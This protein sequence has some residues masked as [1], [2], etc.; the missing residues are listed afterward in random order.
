MLHYT[1]PHIGTGL[2]RSPYLHL[3]RDCERIEPRASVWSAPACRR[4]SSDQ[5][6]PALLHNKEMRDV[7]ERI[8][9]G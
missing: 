9:I 1:T 6:L 3:S 2:P 8:Q 5:N 4:F 7:A